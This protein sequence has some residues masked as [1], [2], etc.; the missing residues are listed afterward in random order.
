ML[1]LDALKKQTRASDSLP[2]CDG[3]VVGAY[4]TTCS[5]SDAILLLWAAHLYNPNYP[6]KLSRS[7]PQDMDMGISIPVFVLW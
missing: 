5:S 7:T 4:R 3:D 1:F 2:G 6:D